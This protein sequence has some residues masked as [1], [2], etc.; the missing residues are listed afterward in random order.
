MLEFQEANCFLRTCC[1]P[2]DVHH[3]DEMFLGLKDTKAKYVKY[4][5]SVDV[6]FWQITVSVQIFGASLVF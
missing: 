2:T 1:R 6:Y 3:I 4:I 5:L